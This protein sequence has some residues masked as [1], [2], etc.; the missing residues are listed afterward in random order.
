MA[1][2]AQKTFIFKYTVHG[3]NTLLFVMYRSDCG[4]Q[5]LLVLGYFP[6]V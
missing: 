3:F 5:A 2:L 6:E 4:R 1:F